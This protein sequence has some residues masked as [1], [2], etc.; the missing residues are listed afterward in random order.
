[1][2]IETRRAPTKLQEELLQCFDE[3][4]NP[5]EARPKSQVRAKP[6]RWWHGV[7]IVWLVNDSGQLLCS[8]RAMFVSMHPGV[9]QTSFGGRV[10]GSMTFEETAVKE[11][12]EETGIIIKQTD[13]HYFGT[14]KDEES[15]FFAKSYVVR[16][17]G[18]PS[19]LH[20][21]D[22]EVAEAKW[23]DMD[24]YSDEVKAHPEQWCNSCPPERQKMIREW[25]ANA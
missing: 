15:K 11:L 5:T 2:G 8:R 19:D 24:E 17:N 21:T 12:A 10:S 16:F 3:D 7:A 13:L 18:E 22:N 6:H 1:M 9:W 4:G 20:F 14:L 23:M 25:L